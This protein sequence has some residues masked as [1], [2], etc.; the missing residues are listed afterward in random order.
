[1]KTIFF[2]I[3]QKAPDFRSENA[4]ILSCV[5]AVV[6]RVGPDKGIW[7]MDRGSD[8]LRLYRAFLRMY[9]NFI[10]RLVGHRDLVCHGRTSRAE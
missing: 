8:R 7:V 9:L 5:S 3:N 10:V 1:M 6:R 2:R 4:Q